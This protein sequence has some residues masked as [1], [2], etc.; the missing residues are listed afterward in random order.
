M[1]TRIKRLEDYSRQRSQE[2]LL[3][4]AETEGE[5]DLVMIFRG[6]SS[7]LWRSTPSDPDVPLIDEKATIVSI[8]RLASP[9]QPDRP[10]YLQRHFTWSEMVELLKEAGV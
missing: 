8:D 9:Y 6:F 1:P 3:V 10:R 7:S 5:I 2:V 4:E